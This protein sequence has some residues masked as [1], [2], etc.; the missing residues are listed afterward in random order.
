PA[1]AHAARGRPLGASQQR[2]GP[3]VFRPRR[4][5]PVEDLSACTVRGHLRPEAGPARRPARAVGADGRCGDAGG[6]RRT[7]TGRGP[8]AVAI[9]ATRPGDRAPVPRV[10]AGPA[11]ASLGRGGAAGA[12]FDRARAGVR[13]GPPAA[14]GEP[15]HP[16]A[17]ARGPAAPANRTLIDEAAA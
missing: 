7:G 1:H 9:V 10:A 3:A 16:A 4:A 8:A 5:G 12:R 13:P 6:A 14:R 15:R 11:R 2:G 17:T